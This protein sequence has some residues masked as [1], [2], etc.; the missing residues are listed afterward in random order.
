MMAAEGDG[1]AHDFDNAVFWWQQA[2]EQGFPSAIQALDV[3]ERQGIITR[4]QIE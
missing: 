1:Q 2:A 4:A 3:L